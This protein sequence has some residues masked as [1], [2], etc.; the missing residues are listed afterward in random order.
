[1][2]DE[3][4]ENGCNNDGE[5]GMF[6]AFLEKVYYGV[7]NG[8]IPGMDS[9]EELAKSYSTGYDSREDAA[10]ALVRWQNAKCAIDGFLT[11]LPGLAFLPA[12]IPLNV[13]STCAVHIQTVASLAKMGGYDLDD[14]RV[15]T[16]VLA[17]MAGESIDKL[18][19]PVGI[20]V[21]EALAKGAINAIPR[22]ILG[23][24]NKMVGAKL[25]TKFSEKGIVQ[26]G[27]IVPFVGGL[28]GGV[29]DGVAS[30]IIGN[31]AIKTFIKGERLAA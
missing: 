8:C 18:L 30:N 25:F 29:V 24:I 27:K 1:M 22:S 23:Q 11:G 9:A 3:K 31:V 26:L 5:Q 7:V 16:L 20:S 6:V 21:A 12:T 13:A 2:T 28:F 10:N 15:K 14:D 19:R 17:C 4:K